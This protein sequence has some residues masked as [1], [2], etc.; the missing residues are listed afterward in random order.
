MRVPDPIGAELGAVRAS[1]GD[2]FGNDIPTHITLLPPTAVSSEQRAAFGHHLA[3]VS[4]TQPT[5]DVR[6]AGTA[7][8]RPVSEVVF[9]VVARGGEQCR[10]LAEQVCAGPVVSPSPFEYH[11]HVTLAHGVPSPEL[12]RVQREQEG[13]SASF[14]VAEIC[15]YEM[16]DATPW[17]LHARFPLRG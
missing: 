1:T 13:F 9:V 14:R 5:F 15:L 3:A 7:S 10:R 2:P 17:R 6:L 11:P 12:D 8:F 16:S 4:A